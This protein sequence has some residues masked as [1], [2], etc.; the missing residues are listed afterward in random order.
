MV[1]DLSNETKAKMQKAV[2]ALGR[3]LMG[4]R[5]G[6]ANPALVERLMVDYYGAPT[7]LHQL[8]SITAPEARLLVIHPWDRNSVHAIEK[9]ILKSELRL[10]PASDGTLIRL[11]IPVLTE[12][13]RKDLMRVVHK[14][15]EEG[16]VE[17]R[18]VRRDALEELREML[19]DKVISE[20][21]QK[22]GQE[23]LQKTTDRFIEE[24]EAVG[25]QKEREIMEV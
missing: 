12:E 22:R 16:R 5:T 25:Q 24:V 19:K 14:K 3:E 8:A 18:N 21:E 23:Q 9:A 11:S 4:I 15:V 20:D 17:V 7:P 2:E 13:R 6:R 1:D 10:P